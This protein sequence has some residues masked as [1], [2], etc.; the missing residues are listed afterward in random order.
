MVTVLETDSILLPEVL[1]ATHGEEDAKS[2]K[3]R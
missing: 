2:G 3:K 1:R